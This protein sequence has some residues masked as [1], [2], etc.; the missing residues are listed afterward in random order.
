MLKGEHSCLKENETVV[1]GVKDHFQSKFLGNG[2]PNSK[3]IEEF[4]TSIIARNL[5]VSLN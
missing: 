2:D 4:R 3:L 1:V 5:K